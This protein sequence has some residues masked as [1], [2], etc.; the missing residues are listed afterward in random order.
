GYRLDKCIGQGSFGDVYAVTS[1]IDGQSWAV[2][3]LVARRNIEEDSYA[4]GEITAL[5]SIHHPTVV[6]L[7]EVL[8]SR[9]LACL[10]ME[11]APAGNLEMFVQLS[12]KSNRNTSNDKTPSGESFSQILSALN[13][14]HSMDLA[15]RDINPSN[16]LIFN[17]N[18]VKL[19]DFGLCFQCRD[20]GAKD[21]SSD[22]MLK[23]SDYLGNDHYLAPEVRR[24][25][26]FYAMPADVWSL[27]CLLY[28]M[29]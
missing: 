19:A 2:K 18:L 13:F 22:S 16:V 9:R 21:T 7:H 14:C 24:R 25:E 20:A 17:K 27:G 8:L 1:I 6:R 12:Y 29:L 3:R 26:P 4:I 15:H 28:F 11:L 10:V 5:A 23:C